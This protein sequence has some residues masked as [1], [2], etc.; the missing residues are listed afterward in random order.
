LR[1]QPGTQVPG[2]FCLAWLR[3]TRQTGSVCIQRC[4]ALNES[5]APKPPQKAPA[6]SEKKALHHAIFGG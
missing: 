3:A 2:F 6:L 1:S 4:Q 5:A